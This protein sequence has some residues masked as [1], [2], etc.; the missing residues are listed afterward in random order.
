MNRFKPLL[1]ILV[2]M[3][4]PASCV[5][6]ASAGVG[7][8]TMRISPEH[9][10]TPLHQPLDVELLVQN[11]SAQAAEID[12]GDDRKRNLVLTVTSPDRKE[13]TLRVAEHEGLARIG[14][15]E[16]QAGETYS[17]HLL[18]NEWIEFAAVGV[19]RIVV[20]FRGPIKLHDGTMAELGPAVLLASV[21][22]KNSEGLTDFCRKALQE[23]LAAK[24]YADAEQAAQWLSYTDDPIAVPYLGRAFET[25]YPIH[26]LLVAGL[27]RIGTDDSIRV[28]LEIMRRNPD[29]AAGAMKQALSRLADRTSDR[30]L[31]LQVRKVLEGKMSR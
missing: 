13:R 3:S 1:A 31:Q 12:L 30:D 18:L 28:L 22:D 9:S 24:T 8:I 4:A 11:S 16:V 27:E 2:V 20:R 10:V 14:R 15:V 29:V 19:Y 23:L 25:P 7:A 26:S 17:Q 5:H 21:T 6:A